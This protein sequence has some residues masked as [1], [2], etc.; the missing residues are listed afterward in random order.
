M[1]KFGCKNILIKGGD[2]DNTDFKTDTLYLG[3]TG[4]T[5]ELKADAVDTK[6]SHGTGCTLSSAI[7]SYLALGYSLTE[8]VRMAK[9]Y[10]TRALEAGAWISTGHG[11]GPVNHF[12]SPRRLKNFNPKSR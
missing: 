7:A 9:L 12:F 10:V 6:N 5:I 8:A 4:E 3:A 11:H 1:R 2:S